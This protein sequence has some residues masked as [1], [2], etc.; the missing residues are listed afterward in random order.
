MLC[1]NKDRYTAQ[2]VLD[3]EWMKNVR[4]DVHQVEK[5]ES[6]NYNSLIE[7]SKMNKFK[8]SVLSFVANRTEN[9]HI[10]ALK[11]TFT[12]MDENE[13]GLITLE[14]LE[15]A[16]TKL[17]IKDCDLKTLFEHIDYNKNGYI[18][19]T[20]FL[21]ACIDEKTY[22][23]EEKLFDAFQMFDKDKSGK[24]SAKEIQNVMHNDEKLSA[25][26]D[27][28]K[29]VDLDEDGEINY[30]EFCRMMGK[31]IRRKSTKLEDFINKFPHK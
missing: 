6:F 1:L 9:K 22:M 12:A 10:K 8:K 25:F 24:I 17:N 16:F 29:Q 30:E 28:I 14:E 3:H 26:K 19:Y 20:E 23:T 11:D 27:M 18:N 13:D 31:Q 4:E 5:M 7:F 2:Q 15:N 21:A